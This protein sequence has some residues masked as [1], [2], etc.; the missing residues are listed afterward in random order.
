MTKQAMQGDESDL[1][2]ASFVKTFGGSMANTIAMGEAYAK[3]CLEFQDEWLRF[4][5]AR[6]KDDV[7][8][9]K[10]LA[11]CDSVSDVV[12]VQQDWLAAA[13]RDYLEE[14]GKLMQIATRAGQDGLSRWQEGATGGSQA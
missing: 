14:A 13:S 10:C 1:T 5:G 11:E 12:K 7:E 8:T 3:A 4:V 9:Q 2:T 6:L